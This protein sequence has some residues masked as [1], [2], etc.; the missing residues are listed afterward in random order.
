MRHGFTIS[1]SF[2]VAAL[3][4]LPRL[5]AAVPLPFQTRLEASGPGEDSEFGRA[6]SVS[7]TTLVVGASGDATEGFQAGAGYVYVRGG[8]GWV[9]QQKVLPGPGDYTAFGSAVA[10]SGDTAVFGAY[11]D[12][13]NGAFAGAAYVF[14]RSGTVWSLQQKITAFDGAPKDFF[15]CSV[16]L[17]GDTLVIGASADD[18]KGDESGS[19]YVFTR[20]GAVWSLQQKVV[21]SDGAAGA[22]FGASVALD[23]QTLV[24]GAPNDVSSG[25]ATGSAYVYLRSGAVW[26][27]QKKLLPLAG[28]DGDGFGEAVALSGDT[29]VVGAYQ[30]DSNGADAGAAYVFVRTGTSWSQ[31]QKLLASDG[32][33]SDAFGWSVAV[34]G[35]QALVGAFQS[36]AP[37][38]DSG[39]AYLF[40]RSGTTWSQSQKLTA[41]DGLAGDLVGFSVALVSNL[42]VTGANGRDDGAVSAGAAYLFESPLSVSPAVV[43]ALA[44]YRLPCALLL[45]GAGAWIV[46]RRRLAPDRGQRAPADS[47]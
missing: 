36:D 15:G 10:I 27:L 17:S 9:L 32:A 37:A 30:D 22:D 7:G 6:V 44:S 33:E 42:G 39:A 14:V 1:T 31:Q 4:S 38:G 21:P 2:A 12:A 45:L 5:A 23:G 35:E 18:D 11:G 28:A 8:S 43:P 46:R 47:A 24:A 40:D 16:A 26:S 34:A 25:I 20:S 19:L 41:S 29:A 3:I 13:Q